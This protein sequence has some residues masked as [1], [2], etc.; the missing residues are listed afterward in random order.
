[1]AIA[2]L[3]AA[4]LAPWAQEKQERPQTVVI[5][6]S[7]ALLRSKPAPIPETLIRL[8]MEG[9]EF[10]FVDWQGNW[11]KIELPSGEIAYVSRVSVQD[12][13]TWKPPAAQGSAPDKGDVAMATKGFSPEMEAEHRKKNNLH[14][15]YAKLDRI[16]KTPAFLADPMEVE[17]RQEAFAREGKLRQ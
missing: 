11:A 8:A 16:E 14:Q 5:H 9:E 17:R 1:M 2:W 12:K 6:M 4:S 13:K 15:A 7:K 10:K 3:V